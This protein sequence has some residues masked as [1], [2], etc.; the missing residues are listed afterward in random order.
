MISKRKVFLTLLI[1]PFL[2]LSAQNDYARNQDDTSLIRAGFESREAIE[3]I[4]L[5]NSYTFLDLYDSDAEIIPEHYKKLFTSP[6]NALDN[7]FQVYQKDQIAVINFRGSTTHPASWIENLYSAMIP[8]KGKMTIGNIEHHYVFAEDDRASVHTGYALALLIKS[9]ELISQ[10]G[11]LNEQGIYDIFLTGHSQGGSLATMAHAFFTH[12]P[13]SV[14]SSSNVFKTYV[15]GSPMCGNNIFAEDYNELYAKS[16][17]SFRIANHADIITKM[18]LKYN[19]ENHFSAENIFG[20]VTGT[21]QFDLKQLGI[22]LIVS[23]FSRGISGYINKSNTM[24]RKLLSLYMGNIE[25]PAY[26]SDINFSETGNLIEIGPFPYPHIELDSSNVHPSEIHQF[27]KTET[28]T[29]VRSEPGFFQHK[30]Y[31]YYVAMLQLYSEPAYRK[32]K[33]KVLPENL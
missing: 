32:L 11:K 16:G 15:F 22:D 23:Q 10:I 1:S 19:S 25:I 31:N 20:W 29:Y 12:L 30:P 6:S 7:T 18:P 28:G 27:K 24:I 2:S 8:A 13:D 26:V 17:F 21:K 3:M 9:A 14:I 33:V 4:A 5:C